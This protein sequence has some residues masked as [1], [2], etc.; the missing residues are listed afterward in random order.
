MVI[1]NSY[2]KLPEGTSLVRRILC[3]LVPSKKLALLGWL[4]R[5]WR[6]KPKLVW[7][8][9][10]GSEDLKYVIRTRNS[11]L[12]LLQ[13]AKHSMPKNGPVGGGSRLQVFLT[14]I[15][16]KYVSILFA[17]FWCRT[18]LILPVIWSFM[19]N[20]QQNWLTS[21][22]EWLILSV[23]KGSPES[24]LTVHLGK[25]RSLNRRSI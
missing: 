6:A 10:S 19:I 9:R 7:V 22:K 2:V 13:S 12:I 3:M 20:P 25:P 5:V 1:F 16:K 24:F 18:P 15:L 17:V 23:Q 14:N 4:L 8:L 21:T 11:G